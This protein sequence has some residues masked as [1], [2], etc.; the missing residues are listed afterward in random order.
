LTTSTINGFDLD[1][2]WSRLTSAGYAYVHDLPE[3]FDHAGELTRLGRLVPQYGGVLVRDVKPD[4]SV[5]N[6]VVSSSNMA[7]LTPHTEWYEFPDA[8]TS[9]G[10]SLAVPAV[11]RVPPLLDLGKPVRR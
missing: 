5:S 4:P 8:H 2:I 9:R 3:G 6:T 10:G 7:E 11:P 1:S